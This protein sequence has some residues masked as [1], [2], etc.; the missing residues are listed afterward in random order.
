MCPA[1]RCWRLL[2]Q[3]APFPIRPD[4]TPQSACLHHGLDFGA[5]AVSERE[6]PGV[7]GAGAARRGQ[8][9]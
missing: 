4:P 7:G 3:L 2:S 1:P 5:P 9:I 8:G 6:G